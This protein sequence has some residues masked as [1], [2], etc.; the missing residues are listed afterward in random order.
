MGTRIVKTAGKAGKFKP[1][2]LM[3]IDGLNIVISAYADY[4]KTV[5]VEKTKREDIK[6]DKEKYIAKINSQKEII[7]SYFEHT[8]SER[9]E[10]FNKLFDALDKGINLNNDMLVQQALSSIITIAK[11]SPLKGIKQLVSDFENDEIDEIEI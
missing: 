1:S 3:V 8:F 10:N 5:E 7:V 2:P 11:D 4:K 9:K 6:A